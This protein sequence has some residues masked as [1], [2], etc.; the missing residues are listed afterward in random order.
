MKFKLLGGLAI[1]TTVYNILI[2]HAAVAHY[3]PNLVLLLG[4]TI[5]SFICFIIVSVNGYNTTSFDW[6]RMFFPSLLSFIKHQAI[7][8]GLMFLEP[9]LHQ[10]LYQ[11]NIIFAALL[12]PRVL[13]H[14]QYLSVFILFMGILVVLYHRDEVVRLPHH[15]PLEGM[16]FTVCA[17]AASALNSQ[18]IEDVVKA[19]EE[20]TWSR[21]LQLSLF[22]L[23]FSVTSS[24]I[25]YDNMTEKVSNFVLVLVLIKCVGD[26]TLPFALKY[27]DNVTKSFSDTVATAVSLCLSQ[28]M[29]HWHPRFG[30]YFGAVMIFFSA[31]MFI[32]SIKVPSQT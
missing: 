5:R 22:D 7:F 3:N 8:Y 32:V 25:D 24:I 10:M 29:Y 28:L 17:A 18:M 15:S 30:F 20:N 23:L 11:I 14:R 1:Q 12:T 6:K 26:M 9:S 2:H 21:Q 27:A 4:S 19:E 16:V 31:Y 13:T